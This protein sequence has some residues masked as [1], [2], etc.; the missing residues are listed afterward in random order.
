MNE[1]E[2]RLLNA[3]LDEDA[4]D[5]CWGELENNDDVVRIAGV[6]QYY[7]PAFNH[8]IKDL[9]YYEYFDAKVTFLLLLLAEAGE[10]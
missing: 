6:G 3:S 1:F 8:Y 4:I 10:L 7:F 9:E 2:L 5:Y